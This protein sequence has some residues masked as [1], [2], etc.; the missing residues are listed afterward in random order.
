MILNRTLTYYLFCL[1]IFLPGYPLYAQF[2]ESGTNPASVR[3]RQ[4]NTERFRVVFPADIE[5]QG[6]YTTNV[7]NYIYNAESKTLNHHPRKIPVVLHNRPAF[8]NGFVSWAPKR[9][10]WYLTPPQTNYSHNWLEQL[11][12]HEYRHV[13]QIDKLNQSVTKG[14]GYAIGQQSVGVVSALLPQWFLEG[15]AVATETA[16]SNAGRGRNPAFEMPLRTIA[17]SD[18]YQKF[19]KA[20]L[21][22]YRDHVPNYYEMGYQLVS[23]SR[24][25]Y[26]PQL[27]ENTIDVVAR[28]PYLFFLYPFKIG[29]KQQTGHRIWE[30]YNHAFEDL[31]NLWEKQDRN[32]SYDVYTTINRTSELYTS[33]RS[34]QY[35]TDSTFVVQKTG[36]AQIPQWVTIDRSGNEKVLFTPGSLNSDRISSVNG[37]I[38]WSESIPDVRWTNRTYSVVKWLDTKTG[39]KHTLARKSR[40]FAPSLSPDASTIAVIDVALNDEH[41]IVLLDVA[42][43]KEKLR[44]PAPEQAQLQTPS[45]GNDGKFLLVIVNGKNG[46]SIAKV[47]IVSGLFITVLESTYDDIAHPVDGGEYLFYTGYYNGITNIYATGYQDNKILQVTSSRFGAFDPQPDIPGNKMLISEYSANGYQLV[48][49]ELNDQQWTPVEKVSDHSVKLYETL[50]LQENFNLQDSIIPEYTYEVK[51]FRKWQHL[52][53]VHS[54]APLYYKIDVSDVTSTGIYP[55]VVFLSQDLLG[56]M[57]SSA[58]YS[59]RGHHTLHADLTYKGLYPVVEFGIEYG[60]KKDVYGPSGEGRENLNSRHNNADIHVRTYVPFNFTR[61]RYITGLVPQVN[62]SYNT[63]Y[64]YSNISDDYLYGLWE[65]A[66]GINFYRYLRTSTRDLAPRWGL[67]LQAALKHTP[68]HTRLFGYMYYVYGRFYFPGIAKHHSLQ[69]SGSWQ[70]QK[71]DYYLYGTMLNFP[72]GYSKARTEKLLMGL[73]EYAFPLAYPDW[74]WTYLMYVRRLSANV[75]CNVADNR[76]QTSQGW[77]SDRMLSVGIDLLADINFFR[78]N[79]PINMGL[80]TIY[81]PEYKEVQPHLLFKISFN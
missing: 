44:I 1:F 18:K 74:N 79:F 19:D 72:R 27:F 15:D 65:L 7:L 60:G 40:Y 68:D 39:K 67:L 17:L 63:T 11:A 75:F 49:I 81:I 30:L 29:L 22:S 53:N 66:Y 47:D 37:Y 45:W 14:L 34:P 41:T 3:W 31:T 5:H 56:N 76:N 54:W 24:K 62:L 4:I 9:S 36:L 26:G 2:Y 42:T 59:W 73:A 16:L 48:E 10:E 33:Y 50:A 20:F 52:F 32:T 13:V 38:T 70:Q 8:S 80:R 28:K 46:K 61:N 6:L 69:L 12:L 77:V 64:F 71:T 23:W 58:G 21:G 55:G 78:M 51:P 25:E 57:T 43:G 35:Y